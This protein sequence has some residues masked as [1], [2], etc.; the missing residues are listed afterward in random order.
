MEL[1]GFDW[2]E[3]NWGEGDRGKCQTHGL[4]IADIEGVFL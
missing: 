2:Y 4:S 3:R 1:Y